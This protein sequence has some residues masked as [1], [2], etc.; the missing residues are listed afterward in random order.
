MALLVF[1][2]IIVLFKIQIKEPNANISPALSIN[3]QTNSIN[4]DPVIIETSQNPED[5]QEGDEEKQGLI[6][7]GSYLLIPKL[8]INAPL[9]EV[10]LTP[11]AAVDTPDQAWLPAWFNQGPLPGEIGTAIIVGHSGL[12][13]NGQKTIFNNLADLVAGDK[14]YIKDAAGLTKIFIVRQLLFYNQDDDAPE[15]FY[16]EDERSHLN[17]ITCDGVWDNVTNSYPTR[18]VVFTDLE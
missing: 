14:I 5:E 8:N 3:V 15:V 16:S 4:E 7:S 2:L 9:G 13:K 12:W 1:I 17:L 18:L 10:G 11:E 6:Y